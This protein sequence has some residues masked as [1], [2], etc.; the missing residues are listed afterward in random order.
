MSM[1]NIIAEMLEKKL[2]DGS[3]EKVIEEKLTKC[4]GECMEDMF[5]WS[6]EAKKLIETKLKEVMVP[7]IENHDFNEYTLKL[8]AVLTEIVNSTS[9]QDNKKILENFKE[10]MVEDEKEINL[11]DIYKKWSEYVKKNVETAGLDVEYYDDPTYESVHI[12][13]E[14][15]D[16][17]NCSKYGPDEKVVRFTC[18]HD[19]DMNIQFDV[20]KYDFMDG[21]KIRNHEITNINALARMDDMQVLIMRLS[22]NSTKIIIDDNY[23]ED[24][25]TPSKEPEASFS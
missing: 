10:L 15:E 23:L 25:V 4:V 2:K 20:Y 8:D 17:E 14:V 19:E 6:G 22:R 9:L 24:D 21:Y 13:M 1:E 7:T 11:S 3:I 18:E 5:R 12:E 16:I